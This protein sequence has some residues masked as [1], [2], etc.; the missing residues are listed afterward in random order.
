MFFSHRNSF[1]D[2]DNT[3]RE[4]LPGIP[5]KF[6]DKRSLSES[7][8]LLSVRGTHLR[9]CF[10]CLSL[11]LHTIE[12][13]LTVEWHVPL[14]VEWHVPLTIEWH[15]PLTVEWHVPLTVEWH[16][17]LT[18]EWHVPL[19]VEWH[20]P[21]TIE[22]HVPLTVEWHVPLTVEWHVPLTVEWH[23]PL[24]IEWHV[25][26]TV[27]W[28]V[29]LTIEWHVPLTV[30]WHVPLT[31][32]WHVPLTVEWHVPLTI[33]WHV[34]LTVEWH[35]PLTVEWHVPLTVEWHVPLTVEWHVPL[36]IAL[37]HLSSV[38][39]MAT[40]EDYSAVQAP[41]PWPQYCVFGWPL[42]Q[43]LRLLNIFNAIRDALIAAGQNTLCCF[44]PLPGFFSTFPLLS[45]AP[46]TSHLHND[47]RCEMSFN[48]SIVSLQQLPLLVELAHS[49]HNLPIPT[50]TCPFLP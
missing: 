44:D 3:L 9:H 48:A 13:P 26:L 18:I 20:V 5:S 30:E 8:G 12:W 15:V 33:E 24:T 49:Y 27:E 17:P 46:P 11:A 29:P 34:P 38:H 2:Q 40:T 19:T 31:V 32:E 37:A 45:R 41:L 6:I 4:T 16:V 21:L 42:L 36:T 22:W 1:S 28:H 7:T 23:V 25:P 14:T 10:L 35:V 43:C 50:I 47:F 39:A